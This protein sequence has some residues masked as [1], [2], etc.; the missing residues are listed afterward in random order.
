MRLWSYICRIFGEFWRES[1]RN[2]IPA[3][4]LHGLRVKE[5]LEA[6]EEFLRISQ[7]QGIR[8]VR[9][10]Y[11]KGKGSPDGK[12]VLREAVPAW[13]SKEGDGY[14]SK[15]QRVIDHDGGDG[16]IIVTIKL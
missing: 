9:I 7:A 2:I 16:S 6:T 3:L 12:G 5:A 4:D 15:F 13:I 10:I 1:S 8:Q 11:G 14:V